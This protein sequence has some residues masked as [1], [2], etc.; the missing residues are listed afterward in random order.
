MQALKLYIKKEFQKEVSDSK[1]KN[2]FVDALNAGLENNQFI[3]S[4]GSTGL[5]GTYVLNPHYDPNDSR[6]P[7]NAALSASKVETVI[8]AVITEQCYEGK[9]KEAVHIPKR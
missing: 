9:P 4:G 5:A 3:R 2:K 6:I 1:Y 7:P 8:D